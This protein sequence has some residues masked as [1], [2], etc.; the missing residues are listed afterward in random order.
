MKISLPR[1][2]IC[3][4]IAGAV[5]FGSAFLFPVIIAMIELYLSSQDIEPGNWYTIKQLIFTGY[6]VV[7]FFIALWV[8]NKIWEK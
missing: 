5:T 1:W 6:L 3:L 7:V 2:F 4:M 8:T